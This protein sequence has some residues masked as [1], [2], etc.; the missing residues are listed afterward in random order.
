MRDAV[1]TTRQLG[2]RF[3]WI[4][5]LCIIQD[6][7]SD[8]EQE[9]SKMRD[10]YKN[11][12]VTISAASA[13]DCNQGFLDLR[14]ETNFGPEP[15]I[16][17]FILPFLCPDGT[18][19]SITL[20]LLQSQVKI[21]EPINDRAWTLQE[22]LLSPRILIYS[23][24]QLF[25]KCKTAFCRDG[26]HLTWNSYS[27]MSG[28]SKLRFGDIGKSDAGG[29]VGPPGSQFR[30]PVPPH[31]TLARQEWQEVIQDYSRRQL[32]VPEDKLPA[33]SAMAAEYQSALQTE[34]LAGLWR[35]YLIFDLMW[36]RPSRQQATR[37]ATF[38]CPSWSWASLDGQIGF[39]DMG[40]RE[41]APEAEIIRCVT[42]PTSALV[43]FGRVNGGE[44]VIQGPLKK[45]DLVIDTA[46]NP[47]IVGDA[48]GDPVTAYFDATIGKLE[49]YPNPRDG[50]TLSDESE[51]LEEPSSA[52]KLSSLGEC[53]SSPP[54][55]NG[56]PGWC[57]TLGLSIEKDESL[58]TNPRIRRAHGLLLTKADSDRFQ[59]VGWFHTPHK[60]DR[61]DWFISGPRETIVII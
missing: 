55:G 22:S 24:T 6:S 12:Y 30:F 35:S 49:V 50:E 10:I 21:N 43:P 3:L 29:Q 60:V 51:I 25:W 53:R 27:N 54:L 39:K 38:R 4:D 18:L 40:L 47:E 57:L 5:S 45:V 37:P 33:L 52:N 44:L 8:V 46:Q 56:V 36:I 48:L 59:R 28:I 61:A 1:F 2:M 23:K 9:L 7:L 58:A 14:P 13:R 34:Y 17:P 32:S 26:G 15:E 42:S 41:F 31:S 16:P 19:A 20:K 11:A